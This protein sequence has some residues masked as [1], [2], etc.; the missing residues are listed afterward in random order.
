MIGV[1]AILVFLVV[2]FPV[3]FF[4]TGALA[5]GLHGWLL[6]KDAEVRHEGSELIELSK[7]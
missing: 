5:S 6:S 4:M 1:V 2:L 7:Q 3:G